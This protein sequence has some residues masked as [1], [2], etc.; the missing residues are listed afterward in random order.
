MTNSF[1]P[2]ISCDMQQNSRRL[3]FFANPYN[4]HN[5]FTVEALARIGDVFIICPPLEL[6]F[7]F[8]RWKN[9]PH[10]ISLGL[11]PFCLKAWCICLFSLLK[12]R[13]ITDKHYVHFISQACNIVASCNS[14]L[15]W[16]H[17]QDYLQLSS[18]ARNNIVAD[19]C[20]LIIR[21]DPHSQNWPT[22]KK[23]VSEA[24]LII[25]PNAQ[26]L[27]PVDQFMT[28]ITTSI[29]PYGGDKADYLHLSPV[30][31]PFDPF[32]DNCAFVISARANSYRKGIDVLLESLLILDSKYLFDRDSITVN[33]II[34]GNITDSMAK[35]YY[36][37]VKT[38]LSLGTKIRLVFKGFNP[39][40]YIQQ[41]RKSDLFIM[42]SKSEG[43]S[44]AALEALWLGVP[45]ILSS[46]CGITNF[47]AERHGFEL[48]PVDPNLLAAY[49]YQF[50][51]DKLLLESFRQ[52]LLDD[53]DLFT[54][55]EYYTSY[56]KAL[57]IFDAIAN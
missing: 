9:R 51:T 49:I 38:A 44:P 34:C 57:S 43:M 37:K 42:P 30:S 36:F 46:N 48:N 31:A 23:A 4:H 35:K 54:W 33:C 40:S 8:G 12:L 27:H 15:I 2:F 25:A 3:F 1:L 20:E 21:S 7:F 16:V 50:M 6:Q 26:T 22:T 56:F 41:L 14:H 53:I 47:V 5:Y 32:D 10:T 29:A 52:N 45:C 28:T 13:L 55:G 39:S 17:Y 19:I 24:N 18:K 11:I